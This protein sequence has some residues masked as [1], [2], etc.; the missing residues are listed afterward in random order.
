LQDFEP[1]IRKSLAETGQLP[2]ELQDLMTV[3]WVDGKAV[4]DMQPGEAAPAPPVAPVEPRK[5]KG[6]YKPVPE[7]G[8]QQEAAEEPEGA[9]ERAR[10]DFQ[11]MT[12][13]QL[14]E[15]MGMDVNW[16]GKKKKWLIDQAVESHVRAHAESLGIDPKQFSEA[17]HEVHKP[18]LEEHTRRRNA[19]R[20]AHRKTRLNP[21]DIRWLLKKHFDYSSDPRKVGGKTG[22]KLGEYDV[23]AERLAEEFPGVFTADNPSESVWEVL[24][25]PAQTEPTPLDSPA[26]LEA[27]EQMLRGADV[28][29]MAE[30][31]E[32]DTSFDFG[33]N[34]LDTAIRD[35]VQKQ[36]RGQRTKQTFDEKWKK[37]GD[38][39]GETF[40]AG[41][42]ANQ[43]SA[44]VELTV[45]AVDHGISVFSEFMAQ[46]VKRIGRDN[47]LQYAPL[48]EKAWAQT[49]TAPGFEHLDEAGTVA[50]V[51]EKPAEEKPKRP[52]G[53]PEQEPPRPQM[54]GIKKERLELQAAAMGM[55]PPN[56]A[57]SVKAVGL[58][59][60]AVAR[61]TPES[62]AK[63][64]E[65]AAEVIADPKKPITLEE[66]AEFLASVDYHRRK[67]DDA[68][69]RYSD[70]AE[71]GGDAAAKV[72]EME[73]NIH[74]AA[75]HNAGQ[76][77]RLMGSQWAY[78]GHIYQLLVD[79]DGQ[80][81]IERLLRK[82]NDGEAAPGDSE[83]AK[84]HADA[85][86]KT[87][88]KQA[89]RGREIDEKAAL[90]EVNARIA[91]LKGEL[92][93]DKT[94]SR[95]RR[96]S[97][98]RIVTQEAKDAA[99]QRIRQRVKNLKTSPQGGIPAG[100]LVEMLADASVVAGYHIEAGARR[101]SDFS[102][103][104]IE[105]LGS[106]VESHLNDLHQ[107]A[108]AEYAKVQREELRKR[109]GEVDDLRGQATNETT[110]TA[111]L[112]VGKLAKEILAETR[113]DDGTF[114]SRQEL[115]KLLHKE[116][117]QIGP[118]ITHRETMDLLA[119]YGKFTPASKD[120]LD[121]AYAER[122]GETLVLRQRGDAQKKL[123]P[124][125]TGKQ[126]Q[127]PSTEERQF[128]K[129]VND[130]K[131]IGERDGWYH[132]GEGK[133]RGALEA[134]K[135]RLRNE[136]EEINAQIESGHKTVKNKRQPLTDPELESLRELRNERKRVFGEVFGTK[137]TD[138]QRAE[139]YERQLERQ[140]QKVQEELKT[141]EVFPGAPQTPPITAK[142]ARLKAELEALRAEKKMMRKLLDPNYETNKK[143][144]QAE[145]QADR[146]VAKL[147]REQ[148]KGFKMKEKPEPVPETER[149]KKARAK[150]RELR[151]QRREAL[152][153]EYA[154]MAAIAQSRRNA[155]NIR[156]RLARGDFAPR[157]R[158]PPR[159]WDDPVWKRTKDEELALRKELAAK[160]AEYEWKNAHLAEKTGYFVRLGGSLWKAWL[161]S[162]DATMLGLQAGPAMFATPKQFVK[163]LV[164]MAKATA[165]P[166]ARARIDA[167]RESHPD[168]ERHKRWGLALREHGKKGDTAATEFFPTDRIVDAIPGVAF[169]ERAFSTFLNELRF[170]AMQAMEWSYSKSDG[171][172]LNDD[173]GAAL[174]RV[175]NAF[176]FAWK[177]KSQR[178]RDALTTSSYVLWAPSMY[179]AR[180][181]VLTGSPVWFNKGADAR[182]RKMAA[183]Q[184]VKA[185]TGIFT[186]TMLARLLWGDDDDEEVV[187][188][189]PDY[190]KVKKGDVRIDMT[191][192]LGQTAM[193]GA[194][195]ADTTAKTYTGER[196]FPT[197]SDWDRSTREI[198]GSF[199][200]FKFHP[201]LSTAFD[202]TTGKD[203]VGR[204]VT[205]SSEL[206]ENIT[207]LSVQTAVEAIEEAGF[208]EGGMITVPGIT[209][210]NVS[211][212]DPQGPK[213]EETF[214]ATARR[215]VEQ[216]A[217]A[218]PRGMKEDDF[219]KW[220]ENKVGWKTEPSKSAK[221]LTP[222]QMKKLKAEVKER[223]GSV[224][225]EGL[226]ADPDVP[227]REK[228]WDDD[229]YQEKLESH[230][231]SLETR[232][233][234]REKMQGMLK[235]LNL[236]YTKAHQLLVDYHRRPGRDQ[237][238]EY[239]ANTAR[240]KLEPDYKAKA[241]ALD[242][243]Y[244]K[245][246]DAYKKLRAEW[247]KKKPGAGG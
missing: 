37:F 145:R 6:V 163:S 200:S 214:L 159:V 161:A 121:V 98:N 232:K 21:V 148:A 110:G 209:G 58:V 179:A 208:V 83:W 227:K 2:E 93:R 244:G 29:E 155:A 55:A 177:P 128:R 173:T 123:A 215:L 94:R 175:V 233:K 39:L 1:E 138:E 92:K 41:F 217:G 49:R 245:P 61:L 162:F 149:L 82:A 124:R 131:K 192:G 68:E 111:H 182:I 78:M 185:M 237:G 220:L 30:T 223:K 87:K 189:Q 226:T 213:S 11:R 172:Q 44:A 16:R 97:R 79:R 188:T 127:P 104:M 34:E 46:V 247:R 106:W 122:R 89:K 144:A 118:D 100:A 183:L 140:I 142:G 169:S 20:E 24:L 190:Y 63:I 153:D 125:A 96:G 25:E 160:L 219:E 27:A 19:K 28:V 12:N 231:E 3:N 66:A 91:E 77:A 36:T 235:T 114:I 31:E 85:I 126:R 146:E 130:L 40:S 152:E 102:R 72:A 203:A 76:A 73:A 108:R 205:L 133:L 17:A 168:Y 211:I 181:Q 65:R 56:P 196:M 176:T 216:M 50:D 9:P 7:P 212:Y 132:P 26:V 240:T 43:I 119:G 107:K 74:K 14:A 59:E 165:S 136:I 64:Q 113:Q 197:E 88:K 13:A 8:R 201:W 242:K 230:Q 75:M 115:L 207:P 143:I 95:K 238:D 199:L 86:D 236:D 184:W 60:E 195:L 221:Y 246:K 80:A 22:E 52:E 84:K 174:A 51:L 32:G 53:Q 117:Q 42:N 38:T 206:V 70:H 210:K 151:E 35:E 45:A 243:L 23:K 109:L 33:A 147:E 57:E 105:D 15:F 204:P 69:D 137:L 158:K 156:D 166:R 241:A 229:T 18:L 191:S 135:T 154:L 71:K 234:A 194:R 218:E 164:P 228:G 193:L 141:G 222:Q 171:R 10:P 129:Q 48:F 139:R 90:D 120:D 225:D 187:P 157:K 62:D 167:E 239:V 202:I 101:L 170:R 150:L 81:H 103:A 67:A 4:L 116:L 99:V 186:L 54:T 198:F 134:Q 224:L 112:A 178:M 47:A 5:P 180:V